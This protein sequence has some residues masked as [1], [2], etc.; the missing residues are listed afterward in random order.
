MSCRCPRK[1]RVAPEGQA[2][3]NQTFESLSL[4]PNGRSLF[5][6][7]EGPLAGDGQTADG[8]NRIRI[9]RYEDRG[10]GGFEPAGSSIT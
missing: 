2:T 5:T 9:L 7:V 1:F 4:S 8:E 6:A 10:K 3:R